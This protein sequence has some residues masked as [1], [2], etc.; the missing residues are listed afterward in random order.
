M[1]RFIARPFGFIPNYVYNKQH[2]DMIDYRHP[3]LESILK[4]TY[5]IIVYQEQAMQIT[6]ALAGY[7]LNE[8]D[9]FRKFISTKK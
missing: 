5:G 2:Q 4:N 7:T 1:W 9:N 8:A 6:Q 3:K